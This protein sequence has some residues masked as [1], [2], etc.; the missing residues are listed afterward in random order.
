[1]FF[2][3]RKGLITRF[4]LV[5]IVVATLILGSTTLLLASP[6]VARNEMTNIAMIYANKDAKVSESDPST[7]YANDDLE[8]TCKLDMFLNPSKRKYTYVEFDLSSI[9][10]NKQITHAELYLYLSAGTNFVSTQQPSVEVYQL[11][12][13]WFETLISW[14]TQPSSEGTYVTETTVS[15]PATGTTIGWDVTSAVTAWYEGTASNY[16]FLLKSSDCDFEMIFKSSESASFSARPRLLVT[17]EDPPTATPTGSPT[18]TDTPTPTSTPAPTGTPTPAPTS[19]PTATPSATATPTPTPLSPSVSLPDLGDAPDSTNNVSL[20]MTAYPSKLAQF[21]TV[22]GGGS[23]P[24]GPMHRNASLRFLLGYNITAEEEADN[25][26]D[27][28]GVS[29]IDPVLNR[30]NKDRGDDGLRHPVMFRHCVP[31]TLSYRI[32]LLAPGPTTIYV[33]VWADW[34]RSGRWGELHDCNGLPAPEWVVKNQTL[35]L[36]GPGVFNLRTPVF[37]PYNE[38][39]EQPLWLRLTISERKALRADGGGPA[40]GWEYGETEDYLIAGFNQVMLPWVMK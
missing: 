39:A 26:P 13:P 24:Y 30:A 6:P 11:D 40:L 32:S 12:S 36:N 15:L 19:T 37:L 31:T 8:I 14:D 25:G 9:P 20:A 10:S 5:A 4:L 33:N 7:N 23:P 22:Y 2:I 27:A 18:A 28:D 21:P 38:H 1:M 29:N 35:H 17:Y 16:G 34:D 3:K